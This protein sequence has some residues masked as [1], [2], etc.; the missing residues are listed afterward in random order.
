MKTFLKN[1]EVG[2]IL[3]LFFILFLPNVFS[4]NYIESRIDP[5]FLADEKISFNVR[6]H[7]PTNEILEGRLFVEVIGPKSNFELFK[8]RLYLYPGDVYLKSLDDKLEKGDYKI[9]IVIK[10]R[11]F[12]TVFDQKILDF[13]VASSCDAK[14]ICSY[15]RALEKCEK[16]RP[17]SDPFDAFIPVFFGVIILGIIL[18]IYFDTKRRNLLD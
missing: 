16:C 3:V 11:F 5:L 14:D 15:E 9:R 17:K 2:I 18:M 6:V 8:D 10:D 13:K 4:Q 7:N 1:F 12:E